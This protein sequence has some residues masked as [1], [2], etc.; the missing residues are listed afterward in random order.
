MHVNSDFFG[1]LA[2]EIRVALS[3]PGQTYL[4][5]ELLRQSGARSVVSCLRALAI[6]KTVSGSDGL[7]DSPAY[8]P[9]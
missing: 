2:R 7:R 1:S 8:T 4:R 6:I 9:G 5:Y 3:S